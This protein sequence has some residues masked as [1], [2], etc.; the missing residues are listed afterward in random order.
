MVPYSHRK[1]SI[2][3]CGVYV[4]LRAGEAP[5]RFVCRTRL[6]LWPRSPIHFRPPVSDKT[7]D[8]S[9]I[10]VS[11]HHCLSHTQALLSWLVFFFTTCSYNKLIKL[12]PQRKRYFCS[13][14]FV[15]STWVFNISILMWILNW[16]SFW[17]RNGNFL[18]LPS[19]RQF[20]FQRESFISFQISQ[21]EKTEKITRKKHIIWLGQ[22]TP[23]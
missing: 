3:K 15:S 22:W 13:R 23:T 17:V 1:F 20:G 5:T 9:P 16:H 19:C 7:W 6:V 10:S 2:L 12:E 18:R 4:L 11:C 21:F 14:N 8:I